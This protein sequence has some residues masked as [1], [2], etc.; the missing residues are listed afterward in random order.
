MTY[1]MSLINIYDA[2]DRVHVIASVR[3]TSPDR[4]ESI[5]TE[6]RCTT[7]LPSTGEDDAR[8]WLVDAL[9]ALLEEI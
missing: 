6:L 8:Q 7:S 5:E 3:A 4:S 2:M 1:R 9:V